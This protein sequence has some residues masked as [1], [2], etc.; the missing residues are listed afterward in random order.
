[1]MLKVDDC[2]LPSSNHISIPYLVIAGKPI[3]SAEVV[4]VRRSEALDCV[5]KF[6]NLTLDG[7]PMV[8][9]LSGAEGRENPFNPTPVEPATGEAFALRGGLFGSAIREQTQDSHRR[10]THSSDNNT[11]PAFKVTFGDGHVKPRQAMARGNERAHPGRGHQGRGHHKG[12]PSSSGPRA[13]RVTPSAGDLDNDLDSY[14][15]AR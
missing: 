8:V 12:A 15:A 11:G 2:H 14:M 1:M 9:K 10:A 4:F 5:K 13:A 6:N 3:G 7:R